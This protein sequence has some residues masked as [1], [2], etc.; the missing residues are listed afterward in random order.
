[1]VSVITPRAF[2]HWKILAVALAAWTVLA[3][4][5][6]ELFTTYGGHLIAWFPICIIV[7][8][9]ME[10]DRSY[11]LKICAFFFIWQ[12]AF[13]LLYL[14]D[15]QSTFSWTT[16]T[17]F[18]A[19]ACVELTNRVLGGQHQ[20]PR[21]YSQLYQMF[22]VTIA[23]SSL[24]AAALLTLN[25]W[26]NIPYYLWWIGSHVIGIM[27]GSVVVRAAYSRYTNG[28]SIFDHINPREFVCVMVV[29][30]IAAYCTLAVSWQFVPLLF[31]I[32]IF[33]T[34][35]FGVSA[36]SGFALVMTLVGAYLSIG[37]GLA[38]TTLE[39]SR[40]EV[41]TMIQ[42]VMIIILAT[43]LPIS[44]MLFA[45]RELESQLQRRNENL[46][47]SITILGLAEQLAGLGRWR[48]N[49]R[50]EAQEWSPVMLELYGM[51]EQLVPDATDLREHLPDGG[52]WLFSELEAHAHERAPYSFD[53]H[54]KPANAPERILRMSVLNEFDRNDDHVAV[55]G[56]AMDVTE[57][58]R[59]EE[60]LDLARGRAVR[61]AAE[62]QKMANTDALT[63]LPNRRCT[64][65]RLEAMMDDAQHLGRPL[66]AIMFDIDHFK[67][68]NDKYGHQAGDDVLVKVAAIARDQ[69]RS[70]DLV[71]RIGGEEFVW[72]VPHVAPGECGRLAERLREAIE[73][74][75][76]ASEHPQVTV[77]MGMAM[78]Q[79]SDTQ[80]T[81]LARADAALYEAKEG[82]R[83][84]VNRA[85]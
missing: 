59:R 85:A 42:G 18:N 76:S 32:V 8:L 3:W 60:A 78:M 6:L 31:A 83:N 13:Y 17:M 51:S 81:L 29:C 12:I 74:G 21:T 77:S 7:G 38:A 41:S 50:N 75:T 54:I 70:G 46:H 39:G 58:I 37:G 28:T 34:V 73:N 66:T 26:E 36:A 47:E 53:F 49:L 65:A 67:R 48:I 64:F 10:T 79:A 40:Y 5:S 23:T 11:W 25:G 16:A 22:L 20:H 52:T 68:V 9:L 30:A 63:G 61:L 55:F 71:G 69:A 80:E 56:V 27:S 19:I 82:G 43:A 35:L 15:L 33:G 1:M 84:R 72:L 14:G 57:Q 4:L 24:T 45:R 2:P 62:A 44:S